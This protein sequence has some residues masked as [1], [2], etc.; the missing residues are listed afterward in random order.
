MSVG[1]VAVAVPGAGPA[2]AAGPTLHRSVKHTVVRGVQWW[3]VRWTNADGRQHA[4]VLSIDLTRKALHIRPGMA[5]GNVNDRQTIQS[6]A[7]RLHAVAGV[8]GDL[9]S[10]STYLPWGGIGVNGS[11]FKSPPRDRPSQFFI[12][13]DGKVGVGSLVFSGVVRQVDAAG[14]LGAKH[15]LSAVNTPGSA[16]SGSLTLFTPAVSGLS[17]H[18]CAAVAGPVTGRF[19]SVKRVYSQVRHFDRLRAGTKMLAACGKAG[20]WLLA[21]APLGQKLRIMQSLTTPSGAKVA[22]FLSGQ[23]TLRKDGKPYHDRASNFHTIGI[24]PETAACVSRD[25]MH[26]LLIAVDGWI[27]R[28]G[29]GAGITLPELSALTAA[30]HC[31]TAVVF[32]GGGSTTMVARKDGV[33]QVL[34]KMPQYYGQRPVPNGL[35]VFRS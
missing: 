28:F 10:W 33:L 4:Y 29:L 20:S 21:H 11:V 25:R 26:V 31:Y 13:S 9:F 6:T 32:D 30:L 35:F 19:M 2:G 24:N 7:A 22:S 15:V 27:S 3:T 23:R 17:L 18:R 14:R 12:R 34:N 1:A 8:N 16:N 5:H